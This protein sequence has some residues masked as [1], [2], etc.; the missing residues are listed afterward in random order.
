MAFMD[1]IFFSSPS[2]HKTSAGFI[3][4][5]AN[6]FPGISSFLGEL[7]SAQPCE[8][9]LDYMFYTNAG[10]HN[11]WH[12]TFAWSTPSVIFLGLPALGARG[13]APIFAVLNKQQE[14]DYQAGS[15]P[16]AWLD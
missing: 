7:C 13:K 4:C 5:S 14:L 1:F 10:L 9:A 8:I 12:T 15:G 2:Q 6:F 11:L 3:I 16:H